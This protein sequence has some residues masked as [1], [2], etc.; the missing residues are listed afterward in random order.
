MTEQHLTPQDIAKEFKRKGMFDLLKKDILSKNINNT[1][2]SETSTNFQ[3]HIEDT[4]QEL[5]KEMVTK[6]NSLLFKKSKSSSIS[7]VE[8]EFMK[9]NKDE[10]EGI[11]QKL[12]LNNSDLIE[13]IKSQ[14]RAL[15]ESLNK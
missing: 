5:V 14:A 1:D 8:S 11:L 6:D 7:L 12:I 15:E 2:G 9:N 3:K 13:T 10:I 4:I